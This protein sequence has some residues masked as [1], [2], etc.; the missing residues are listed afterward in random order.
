MIFTSIINVI[1]ILWVFWF[2]WLWRWYCQLKYKM[3]RVLYNCNRFNSCRLKQSQSLWTYLHAYQTFVHFILNSSVALQRVVYMSQTF[4]SMISWKGKVVSGWQVSSTCSCLFQILILVYDTIKPGD[5]I[6]YWGIPI[7]DKNVYGR[8]TH[9]QLQN[10]PA[11]QKR[12]VCIDNKFT[13]YDLLWNERSFCIRA[14]AY[15][16]DKILIA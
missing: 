9:G 11:S 3:W 5:W 14:A 12:R 6:P 4:G 16:N 7:P 13:L 15:A 2:F 8:L 10:S 1:L